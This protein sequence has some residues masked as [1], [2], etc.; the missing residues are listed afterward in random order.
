VSNFAKTEPGAR[1]LE[2]FSILGTEYSNISSSLTGYYAPYFKNIGTDVSLNNQIN[3]LF[4]NDQTQLSQLNN[5]INTDESEANTAYADS[6]SWANIGNESENTYNYN[7][8]L[9]DYNA[10]TSAINQYN[11]LVE[12]YNTLVT[13]ITGGEQINQD[14]PAQSQAAQ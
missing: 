3:Q 4:Q 10:A 6:V 9:Q 1:D 5:T 11:D 7:I 13:E 12:Q 8:Y 14:A 2:L